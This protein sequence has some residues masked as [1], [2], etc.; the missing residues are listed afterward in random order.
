MLSL[1]RLSTNTISPEDLKNL[2]IE[3]ESKLPNNYELPKIPR[4]V[5]W[6][7][8]KTL[9]CITYLENNEIMIIL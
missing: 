7:F 8:Y 9:P 5:I 3:V 1:H 4:K 6:Y 2:L